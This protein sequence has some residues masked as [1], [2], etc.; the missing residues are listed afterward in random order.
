MFLWFC[1]FTCFQS[2]LR[3]YT[4]RCT[5]NFVLSCDKIFL[6]CLNWSTTCFRFQ[7]LFWKNISCSQFWWKTHTKR[8]TN[9]KVISLVRRFSSPA[10]SSW[11]VD[12]MIWKMEECPVSKNIEVKAWSEKFHF[13][14]CSAFVYFVNF[15][16]C[17]YKLF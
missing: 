15:L 9:N 12:H 4:I 6:P 7:N 8:S 1:A 14:F 11:S 13:W 10:L 3:T 16:Y 17:S 5:N 2:W